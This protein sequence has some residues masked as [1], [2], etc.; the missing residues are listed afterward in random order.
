MEV[1]F[2]VKKNTKDLN[3][4]F[5]EN[6]GVVKNIVK[7]QSINFSGERDNLYFTSIMLYKVGS[8]PFLNEVSI[9]FKGRQLSIEITITNNFC[10]ISKK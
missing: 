5:T 2:E 9:W 7:S 8:T 6:T 4:N 3:I 1:Q 10:N